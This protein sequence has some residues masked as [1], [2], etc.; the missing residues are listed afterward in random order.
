[1]F[2]GYNGLDGLI[3]NNISREKFRETLKAG[4]A[5][6]D[7]TLT[8]KKFPSI[9]LG[10]FP[11]VELYDGPAYDTQASESLVP[12]VHEGCI[13]SHIDANLLDPN[14]IYQNLETLY[15]EVLNINRNHIV[16]DDFSKSTADSQPLDHETEVTEPINTLQLT[17]DEPCISAGSETQ[18]PAVSVAEI[19]DE[20]INCIG[21]SKRQCN[22]LENCGFYTVSCPAIVT[23]A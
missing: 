1:M 11:T 6:F 2:I 22:Q 21:L 23:A 16:E 4:S 9:S 10:Y 5:E 19:L 3:G 15:A 20:S 12:Q 13:P 7:V 14:F 8:C 18:L 17:V